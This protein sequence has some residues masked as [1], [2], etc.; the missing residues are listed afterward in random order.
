MSLAG[1]KKQI[2][3]ANQYV[4]EKMG[5]VEGTKM[6]DEFVDMERKTEAITS[7]V[8]QLTVKTKEYLHPN[9]AIRAKMYMH[10]GT[11][12]TAYPQTEG[13]IGDVML[14]AGHDLDP[15]DSE[16][17]SALLDVGS[18]LIEV[19]DSRNCMDAHVQENFLIPLHELETKDLKELG[20]NR[21]KLQG[22][23]LDF[24]CKKRKGPGKVSLE[25]VKMA[26]Y[27]FEESKAVC[28]EGMSK[29]LDNEV[30]MIHQLSQ[31]VCGLLEFHKRSADTLERVVLLLNK[32][33]VGAKSGPT[34]AGSSSPTTKPASSSASKAE[35]ASG[36]VAASAKGTNPLADDSA[37]AT[38][39][40]PCCRAKSEYKKQKDNE[41]SF[42]EGQVIMLVS[43]DVDGEW[44]EG[45]MD[46]KF[47]RFPSSAVEIVVDL[48]EEA[49]ETD[50]PEKAEVEEPEAKPETKE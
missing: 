6:E 13:L 43:K 38:E 19:G 39:T 41:L 3:K 45:I 22:R 1:F 31:L 32:R 7:L 10:M 28:N 8:S 24:D 9:P 15:F 4:S 46:G 20:L 48:P 37:I 23:R 12:G 40:K 11:P 30:E 14:K 25:E 18:A 2:N 29:L 50:A 27:K 49:P 26:Q 16:Y 33:V 17:A 36:N 47:G 42:K 35:T 21:K 44:F 34:F 5:S